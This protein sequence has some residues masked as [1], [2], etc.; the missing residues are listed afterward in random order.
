LAGLHARRR[1][2][3]R[4]EGAAARATGFRK[5]ARGGPCDSFSAAEISLRNG[6]APGLQIQSERLG[7]EFLILLRSIEAQPFDPRLADEIKSWVRCFA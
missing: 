7:L 6:K 1:V 2:L 3:R 5:G 4:D